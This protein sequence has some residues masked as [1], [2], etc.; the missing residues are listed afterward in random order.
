[1]QDDTPIKLSELIMEES[2]GH[3]C[4]EYIL[5]LA[6]IDRAISDYCNPTQE[7]IQSCKYDLNGFFFDNNPKPFNLVYICSMLLDRED[8]VAKIRQRIATLQRAKKSQSYRS[9]V[10]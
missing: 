5:W 1:M 8:A 2:K 6:V 3:I 10:F 4:P 9:S 7:L